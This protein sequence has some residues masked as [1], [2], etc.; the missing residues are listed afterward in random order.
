[1]IFLPSPQFPWF[2]CTFFFYFVFYLFGIFSLKFFNQNIKYYIITLLCCL[3]TYCINHRIV[4]LSSCNKRTNIEK[5][6]WLMKWNVVL[7]CDDNMICQI[8][9]FNT[10]NTYLHDIIFIPLPCTYCK[11]YE[12]MVNIVNTA[13]NL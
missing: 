5:R 13:K 6:I 11:D 4:V 8:I 3:D 1:M 2:L 7:T 10:T 12:I 9:A